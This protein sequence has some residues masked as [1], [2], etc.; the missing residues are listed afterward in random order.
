MSDMYLG[1]QAPLYQ[2]VK[3][4]V[5]N[6]KT[7]EIR[8]ERSV[9]NRVTKLMLWGIA[10]F[11][12]GA[13]ND[14]T[15]DKIYEYIPRY[16]ALGS[17]IPGPDAQTAGVSTTVTVN[18]S[19]LLNEYK[20]ISSNGRSEPV[21]RISIQS[22]QHSKLTTS[23]ND[24]FVKL[25]LST[26]VSSGMYDGLEI[27]EAGLFS[28]EYDNNCLA[29]VVFP[30][31]KKNVG[32]VIDI[33]WEITILSYGN[34]K[35]AENVKIEGPGRVVIP[36]TYTPYHIVTK[37]IGLNYRDNGLFVENVDEPVFMI[38]K[39]GIISKL[40]N[41]EEFI[42]STWD[43]YLQSIDLT[44]DFV[45]DNLDGSKYKLN[46]FQF[47]NIENDSLPSLF[48]LGD[49]SRVSS[50]LTFLADNE[51][52]LLQDDEYY[53]LIT[54]ELLGGS[55]NSQPI[56]MSSIYE[57]CIEYENES[58][59]CYLI[60]TQDVNDYIIRLHDGDET[61]Y[62]V[63]DNEIFTIDE[64]SSNEYISTNCFLYNGIIVNRDNA[65]TG[66]VYN[67]TGSIDKM[68]E[69][70]HS[71]NDTKAFL[72]YKYNTLSEYTFGIYRLNGFNMTIDT[73]YWI[74]W[75]QDKEVYSNENE[76]VDTLYHITNDNYFAIGEYSKLSAYITPSDVTD[77]SVTWSIVNNNISK[78]NQQGVLTAWN[79]GQTIAIVATTN[80]IRS[81]VEVEVVKNSQIIPVEDIYID[82]DNVT[83]LYTDKEKIVNI[84]AI[85]T[86]SFSTYKTVKW[87]T[88]AA[89][90]AICDFNVLSNNKAQVRLNASGN[91]GRGVITATTQDG[92]SAKCLITVI[93]ESDDKEDCL[94]LRYHADQ[95]V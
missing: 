89:L 92:K 54:S 4:R 19:R 35:Y 47:V 87:S 63:I 84:A 31:F 36:I 85:V 16:I 65:P 82:P 78:I 40:K 60:P 30:P 27:G 21:K 32:E 24:P 43:N 29:R 57:E 62:K 95:Q 49:K 83:I 34:T 17:C 10:Q 1:S 46:K 13:F 74:D 70:S 94:D 5:F 56:L 64:S 12:S 6:Q 79:V 76:Q 44:L 75:T 86:P 59:G 22:R 37:L 93:Y 7:G 45:Y 51:N 2:N 66:Y 33:Q 80:N 53:Q 58:T 73:N 9:K 69:K 39:D 91:V 81:R 72:A 8:I 15:P 11:L 25:S 41:K 23:F 18:D 14:S 38:S 68:I 61:T 77:K 52:Y 48:Y 71:D 28:K 88:D 20:Y 50:T 90:E 55:T 42:G 3:I 26:Y 67:A